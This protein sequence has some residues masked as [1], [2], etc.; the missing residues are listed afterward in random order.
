M[1]RDV[2]EVA[3]MFD[4]LLGAPA[5]GLQ[6]T[7]APAKIGVCRTDMWEAGDLDARQLL[8][9]VTRDIQRDTLE[10]AEFDLPL[11]YSDLA[12]IHGRIMRYESARAMTPEYVSHADLLS[13]RFCARIEEGLLITAQVHAG[14]LAVMDTARR[15]FDD[16]MLGF[17][18]LMTLSAVG[19]APLGLETTGESTF[20]SVWTL[21]GVPCV[22][23]PLGRGRNGLP[24]GVQLIGARYGDRHLLGVAQW[25][26][27]A[28]SPIQS[29][30]VAG[31]PAGLLDTQLAND[32]DI[33]DAAQ[34]QRFPPPQV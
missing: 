1:A 9:D 2:T 7:N 33:H 21:L 18:A 3:L 19:E 20:N 12:A 4:A 14:D 8:E 30:V 32:T 31:T 22:H 29:G 16:A 15:C 13:D 28:L 25:L 5:S 26:E 10:V 27:A 6:G 23:V 24:L 34:I 17:D 11:A